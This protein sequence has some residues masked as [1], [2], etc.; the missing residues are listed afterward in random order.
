MLTIAIAC[1]TGACVGLGLYFGDVFGYGWSSFFGVLSM[2]A[3]NA[4]AGYLVKKRIEAVM[5]DV[6]GIMLAGK[7]KMESKIARWQMRPPGSMQ[8][9]QA[10]LARDTKVFVADALAAT[11][12]L[13]A[14][15]LWMPLMRRQIA[16]TQFQ[17]LWMVKDFA[18]AD[19]LM[20]KV[21][22]V[23]PAIGAMKMARMYMLD[24]PTE[25]IAAVY[26]KASRR[27]RYNQNTLIAATWSWIL[28]KRGDVDG[29][30]KALVRARE[31]SDNETLRA[32]REQLANNR[33]AHFSNAALGEQWYA[34]HLEE[35]RMRQP[36][37]RMQWR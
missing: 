11:E 28:V 5:A 15:D 29:A 36:R 18:K 20:P 17:L 24:R 1:A 30:F 4:V 27:L 8:Q 21:M 6:Q 23:D 10:E 25:E 34:L 35:P 3:V 7:K 2:I 16:T 14:F 37:Q 31:K 33:V 32:N 9:A 12:R 19:A 13:H 22:M 26:A